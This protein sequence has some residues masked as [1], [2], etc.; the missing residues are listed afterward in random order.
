MR[1]RDAFV[2]PRSLVSPV[3]RDLPG[4]RQPTAEPSHFGTSSRYGPYSFGGRGSSWNA[5]TGEAV[6]GR[7][8]PTVCQGFSC[9][10]GM[11]FDP[12]PGLR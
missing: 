8:G 3:G 6:P 11:R 5:T 2:A 9:W 10:P 1:E 4:G 12:G 7:N